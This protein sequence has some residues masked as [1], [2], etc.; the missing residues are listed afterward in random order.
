MST[1]EIHNDGLLPIDFAKR[2]IHK[3]HQNQSNGCLDKSHSL[4]LQK[5]VYEKKFA[6]C[7][8]AHGIQQ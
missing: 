5:H 7:F 4:R 6:F 3:I 1:S 2:K 8:D